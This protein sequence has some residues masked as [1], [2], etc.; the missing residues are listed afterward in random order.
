[1]QGLA[2]ERFLILPHPEVADFFRHKAGD[3][4]RWLRVMCRIHEKLERN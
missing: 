3:Y 4:D 1:M 2:Q